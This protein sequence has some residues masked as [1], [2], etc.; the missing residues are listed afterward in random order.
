MDPVTLAA[1]FG[2]AAKVATPTPAVSGA[3]GAFSNQF[4][5]NGIA[6]WNVNMGGSGTPPT[7]QA[8]SRPDSFVLGL[9]GLNSATGVASGSGIAVQNMAAPFGAGGNSWIMLAMVAV[10]A[11]GAAW[12]IKK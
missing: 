12:L 10:V 7:A 11:A 4:Q 6:P 3:N 2:A 9:T 1:L 5:E 8:F